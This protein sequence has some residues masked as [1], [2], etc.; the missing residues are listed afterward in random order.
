MQSSHNP[1]QLLSDLRE[2]IAQGRKRIGLLVGAGAPM[3]VRIKDVSGNE[4]GLIPG[5]EE[6]TNCTVS[7]LQEGHRTAVEEIRKAH[8]DG[9][10]IEDILSKLRLLERAI[11]NAKFGEF[12]GSGYGDIAE[13]LCAQI[14]EIVGV[15]LPEGDTPY[16]DLVN[17][18]DGTARPHGV[19]I[20]TTNYD[21]LFE[22]AL[23]R[24]SSPYF[25][26]FT[27]GVKS[28]FDPVT[29]GNDDLPPRWTRLWKIHGSLGWKLSGERVTRGY[30][31]DSSE[32]V[33]PDHLKYDHTQRQPYSALFDRLKQ[34]LSEPD[35]ILLCTGFSFRDPHITS[36]LRESLSAN[37]N[38][39]VFA[40]QFGK[41]ADET[42][43]AQI[44]TAHPNFSVYASDGAIVGGVE[45]SWQIEEDAKQWSSI[46]A[47][48]WSDGALTLGDFAA[49]A[50]FLA[51]T[52]ATRLANRL[53]SE[54]VEPQSEEVDDA[55]S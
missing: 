20:F 39:A 44:G 2:V 5:V 33:Y 1:D 48:Y 14:G 35:T 23:E 28:F 49:F 24:S 55:A 10:N 16:R 26:G 41:L 13:A 27:G 12:D 47:M 38:A 52:K 4:V 50:R 6:L 43:A 17:W 37:A 40:F 53:T 30:G 34:F 3:A 22:E 36:V 11:G 29:V 8:G 31:K 9:A 21:L 18:I 7:K 32:L 25:D 51:L 45:G 15:D 54:I 19:E 42:A 46:R